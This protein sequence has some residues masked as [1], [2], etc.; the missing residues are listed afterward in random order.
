M[1]IFIRD[2]EVTPTATPRRPNP[3]LPLLLPGLR[4]SQSYRRERDRGGHHRGAS[5]PR[6]LEC[7]QVSLRTAKIRDWMQSKSC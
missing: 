5:L 2:E 3:L 6:E 4:V 1:H 7:I